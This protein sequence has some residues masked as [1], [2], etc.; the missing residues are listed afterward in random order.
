M[1]TINAY[2]KIG[3]ISFKKPFHPI[4]LGVAQSKYN[5]IADSLEELRLLLQGWCEAA[6]LGSFYH[7]HMEKCL[8]LDSLKS[9]SVSLHPSSQL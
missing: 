5:F 7:L 3:C 6:V 2:C 4:L 8:L 1:H 9:S